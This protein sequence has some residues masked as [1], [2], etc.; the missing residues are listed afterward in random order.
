[1]TGNGIIVSGYEYNIYL[2]SGTY[3]MVQGLLTSPGKVSFYGRGLSTVIER[4]NLYVDGIDSANGHHVF[5]KLVWKDL[6]PFYNYTSV[7]GYL[8]FNNVLFDLPGN[9]GGASYFMGS[10]YSGT[11][12]ELKN[13]TILGISQAFL[14][15]SFSGISVSHASYGCLSY[16]G[17]GEEGEW[18]DGNYINFTPQVDE[19]T[20]RITEPGVSNDEYGVYSR[21]ICMG[22]DCIYH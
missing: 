17:L 12:V 8:G 18:N 5:N 6:Q 11:P 3:S 22:L 13:C 15:H 1:M 14:R 2:S 16:Y 20:F 9:C 19:T 21:R 7:G 4:T 10:N